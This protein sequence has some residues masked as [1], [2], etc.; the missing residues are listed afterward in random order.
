MLKVTT[1]MD[2]FGMEWI[3]SLIL[4]VVQGITEFLPVSSSGHL[5][6]TQQGFAWLTGNQRGGR[7]NLFFDVMLHVGTVIAILV[8]YRR[9]ILEGARGLLYNESDAAAGFDRASV[10]RVGVLAAVATAPLVVFAMVFKG[11]I[12]GLFQS[13]AAAGFGFLVTACILAL[14]SLKLV[15]T[16]KGRGA[17]QMTWRDALLIGLAQMLAPFPGVSRSGTTI[18]MAL[19]LGLSRTWAVGFSLLIAIP[20]TLGAIV[21]E[22]NHALA[23]P[24]G[25]GLTPDRVA[26][27]LAATVLAGLVGYAAI[28]WLVRVVRESRIW[29]FSVYL[30]ILAVVVLGLTAALERGDVGSNTQALDRPTGSRDPGSVAGSL[31]GAPLGA[32]GRPF[33]AGP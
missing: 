22:L 30:T 13:S 32:L 3:E 21:L 25:L 20:A 9:P 28:V 23:D 14:I 24:A 18:A 2:I 15:G 26:Q 4:G 33:A 8:H 5:S 29:Y 17:D 6:I 10:A 16:D 31:P 11:W 12:E 1:W 7:E 27:T 19:G